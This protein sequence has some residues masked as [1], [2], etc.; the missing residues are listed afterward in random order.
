MMGNDE[1]ETHFSIWIVVIGTAAIL[2]TGFRVKPGMTNQSE[3]LYNYGLISNSFGALYLGG[4][5]FPF[6]FSL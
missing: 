1:A 6:L 4:I 5:F 3:C 2:I